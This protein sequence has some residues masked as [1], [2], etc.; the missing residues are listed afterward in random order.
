MMDGGQGE[1][2]LSVYVEAADQNRPPA[3]C[4]R[5]MPQA[6]CNL[7]HRIH[8]FQRSHMRSPDDRGRAKAERT[9]DDHIPTSYVTPGSRHLHLVFLV[10]H[11]AID[12]RSL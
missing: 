3:P 6:P 4:L 1:G 5:V 2:E 10:A 11:R 8:T 12:P 9:R 7:R